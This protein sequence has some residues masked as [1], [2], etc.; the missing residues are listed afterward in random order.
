MSENLKLTHYLKLTRGRQRTR[1][2]ELLQFSCYESKSY[3]RQSC[4][5]WWMCRICTAS[6]G[7]I[8]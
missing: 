6:G 1:R 3:E 4:A 7:F 2:R 5:P 8:E